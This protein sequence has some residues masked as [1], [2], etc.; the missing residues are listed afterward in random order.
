MDISRIAA[1]IVSQEGPMNCIERLMEGN[2]APLSESE[3]RDSWAKVLQVLGYGE[4]GDWM[5]VGSYIL[6]YNRFA[7]K[8][9]GVEKWLADEVMDM[10]QEAQ[11]GGY[12][13]MS[14][15][16]MSFVSRKS[17]CASCPAERRLSKLTIQASGHFSSLKSRRK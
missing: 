4:V 2:A 5:D 17:A 15:L 16:G 7:A 1:R 13:Q 9:E 10:A 12:R 3:L 8:L 14:G 11:T 6:A